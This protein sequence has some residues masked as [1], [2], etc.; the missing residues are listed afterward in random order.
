MAM[1]GDEYLL[2]GVAILGEY[3]EKDNDL[4]LGEQLK[5]T[6]YDETKTT[7]STFICDLKIADFD[8]KEAYLKEVAIDSFGTETTT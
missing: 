8:S 1:L 5:M 6:V 2:A 4:N 3:E 7:Y